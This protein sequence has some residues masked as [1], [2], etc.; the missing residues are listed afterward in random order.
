MRAVGERR[1]GPDRSTRLSLS[2]GGR[3]GGC[4]IFMQDGRPEALGCTWLAPPSY[5]AVAPFRK[6]WTIAV[7]LTSGASLRTS[8]IGTEKCP[9]SQVKTFR[10]GRTTLRP[11]RAR[12]RTAGDSR[13]GRARKRCCA[14]GRSKPSMA[15]ECSRLRAPDVPIHPSATISDGRIHMSASAP[16]ITACGQ[17]ARVGQQQQRVGTQDF[18]PLARTIGG[19]LRRHRPKARSPEHERPARR[20]PRPARQHRPFRT[21]PGNASRSRAERRR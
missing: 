12:R 8:D 20:F 3:F 5:A 6:P 10:P 4:L 11:E 16:L 2:E 9:R 15:R 14:P 17:I 13:D 1:H 21:A 19:E 18:R 7:N